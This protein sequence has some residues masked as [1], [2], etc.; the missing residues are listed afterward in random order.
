MEKK[1][2]PVECLLIKAEVRSLQDTFP[3]MMVIVKKK[4]KKEAK[5]QVEQ[6]LK[7]YPFEYPYRLGF[8]TLGLILFTPVPKTIFLYTQEAGRIR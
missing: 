2:G 7:P 3:I 1:T 8:E 6:E 4:K 5:E